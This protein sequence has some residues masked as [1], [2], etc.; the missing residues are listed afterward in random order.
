MDQKKQPRALSLEDIFAEAAERVQAGEAVDAVIVSYAPEYHKQLR[1]LLAIVETASQLHHAEIPAIAADRRSANRQA[2]LRAA[3]QKRS[4]LAPVVTPA[5]RPTRTSSAST[6]GARLVAIWS[7]LQ[8]SF[9]PRPLRLA[10]T[11]MALAVLVFGPTTLVTQ[12]QS[13]IP[14][15]LT[16]P[17]KQWIRAQEIAFTPMER[18]AAVRRQQEEEYRADIQKAQV[19]A[20]QQNRLISS[21]AMLQFHGYVGEYMQIGSLHVM[22]CYQPDLNQPKCDPIKLTGNLQPGAVV[23]LTYQILPGQAKS[24]D[25]PV[26]QGITV[27]VMQELPTEQEVNAAAAPTEIPT[28]TLPPLPTDTPTP[29]P[30]DTPTAVV[31]TATDEP[32]ANC[33]ADPSGGW[34]PYTVQ[35][36]D[37]LGSLATRFGVT[38]AELRAVN[39]LTGDQAIVGTNLLLP[40]DN[41][42]I[43]TT[44]PVATATSPLTATVAPPTEVVSPTVEATATPTPFATGG[45]TPTATS[46]L[47]G[48]VAPPTT[49][50]APPATAVVTSTTELPVTTPAT[51]AT[52]PTPTLT[53]TPTAPA[54]PGETA[55]TAAPTAEPSPATPAPSESPTTPAATEAAPPTVVATAVE[56]EV[57]STAFTPEA[58]PPTVEPVATV[59]PPTELP[60][61]EPP[62]TEPP[63]LPTDTPV[64]AS[65]EVVAA[66]ALP[67]PD[68]SNPAETGG[69]AD[70]TPES[71]T[72]PVSPLSQP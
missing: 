30:T 65:L 64:A 10:L 42:V 32:A 1:G 18:L 27:E 40:L 52:A 60:P 38:V 11:V 28:L 23:M 24:Q 15:D 61:T 13:S 33:T 67:S 47:T 17:V 63:L 49:P 25:N 4:Q 12:A 46:V 36:D 39:C 2:L 29:L 50:T 59:V 3:A 71:V 20:D 14:G 72:Q 55:T 66:E 26:V 68:L 16:Y 51:T 62:P 37:T 22:P 45:V 31:V 53:G 19:K 48:T 9:A 34:L 44:E 43:L 35:A 57:T 56:E 21:H 69:T 6:V 54:T 8:L 70:P 7:A 5:M 58:E 41:E